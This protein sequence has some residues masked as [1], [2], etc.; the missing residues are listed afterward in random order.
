MVLIKA[1]EIPPNEVD[2]PFIAEFTFNANKEKMQEMG[3][4][5][6]KIKEILEKHFV[7]NVYSY[8]LTCE[9]GDLGGWLLLYNNNPN[10]LVINPGET[11]GGF[12]IISPEAK[13]PEEIVK[14]LLSHAIKIVGESEYK[15]INMVLPKSKIVESFDSSILTAGF[16]LKVNYIDM[17]CDL[18][19]I[20]MPKISSEF[21]V[22]PIDSVSNSDLYNCYISAFENGYAHFFKYQSESE[23]KEYFAELYPIG[24][25]DTDL[26]IALY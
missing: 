15:S 8:I 11:L 17:T 12:P 13:Q 1:Q 18:S 10:E 23:T 19:T 22:K 24:N 9:D 6:E 7:Q 4:S 2:F 5:L 3:L 16:F 20:Q 21:D 14:T 25:A 26:S